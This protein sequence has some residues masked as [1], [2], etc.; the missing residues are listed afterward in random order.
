VVDRLRDHVS[1]LQLF[2][3]A[4][5]A[6]C[7]GVGYPLGLVSHLAIGWALVT[8]GGMLLVALVIVTIRRMTHE[9]HSA[10]SETTVRP[11]PSGSGRPADK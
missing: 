10:E 3:M 2:L 11:D 5:T 7:Y 8:L 4:A 9:P 1:N 6:A